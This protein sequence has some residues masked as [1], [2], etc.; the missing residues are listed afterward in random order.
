MI[1]ANWRKA[2][3]KRILTQTLKTYKIGKM[4]LRRRKEEA[5][6]KKDRNK[7]EFCRIFSLFIDIRLNQLNKR[8]HNDGNDQIIIKIKT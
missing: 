3:K 2:Q 6:E 5:S 4:S 1:H 8:N 7:K